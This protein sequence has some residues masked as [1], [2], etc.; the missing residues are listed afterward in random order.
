M[1]TRTDE[2]EV[3]ATGRSGEQ[4]FLCTRYA[5]KLPQ[6]YRIVTKLLRSTRICMKDATTDACLRL[7][8]KDIADV[9]FFQGPGHAPSQRRDRDGVAVVTPEGA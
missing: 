6:Y 8:M 7:H 9:L 3:K 2:L 5:G 1:E 4:D